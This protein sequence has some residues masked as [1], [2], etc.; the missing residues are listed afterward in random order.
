MA[1]I[2]PFSAIRYANRADLSALLAPPYDVLDAAQKTALQARDA[3]NI[4][5]IDLPHLPPKTAGP[6]AVY[7]KAA[8]TLQEWLSRDVMQR[9]AKPGL[10]AYAQTYTH[11]G[12]TYNRRGLFALV[13]LSP[14]GAGQVV[15]HELTY[16]GPIEDRLKLMRSAKAQLSPV[17]GLFS[18]PD[19]QVTK[20]LFANLG[21]ADQTG[22]MD[23]VSNELWCVTD[24]AVHAKVGS[25]MADRPVYIADGHHRYT[26]ALQYQKEATEAAG[27]NLPENH[28]AN[29]ALFVLVA[30]QDPG[31]LILPTHRIL[32][33][34]KDFSPA[35]LEQAAA[36][37][38]KLT[39]S[40]YTAEQFQACADDLNKRPIHSF[41]LFDGA[42]RKLFDLTITDADVLA[43]L[44]PDRSADW[45][46]LDVAILQRYLV[47]ELIA[48]KFAVGG[49]V[50][51]GYTADPTMVGK[52]VDGTTYQAALMLQ[53]TPLMA[54]EA[55]GK[56]KE[57]MPQ[58]STYFF[59][60]LATGMVIAPLK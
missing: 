48:P 54:L 8:L 21:K 26:T 43:K 40:A 13:K 19:N 42:T 58:K 17:F 11:A 3:N 29:Y 9:D 38:I 32:G 41:V 25:L 7:E 27:G 2:K 24:P 31:L 1:T 47:E 15:P 16:K 4:V 35:S 46:Q 23:H 36:G 60:K 6:D 33:N 52:M 18:D 44:S 10:Y 49:E 28:P 59:P 39:P 30:M 51:R 20:T 37:K 5:E 45:R 55:L 56:H 34:L 50:T 12:K 53:P 57:V 22:T 14:F